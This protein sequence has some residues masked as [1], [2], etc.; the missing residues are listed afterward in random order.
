[1]LNANTYVTDNPGIGGVIRDRYE[2][3]YVE[4]IPEHLPEGEGPNIWIWIEKLGRT[5]LDVV[6][7]ISRDLHISRK[8]TGFAG[9]KDKKAITRQWICIS[10]MESDEKLQEVLDLKDNIHNT[11]FLKVVRGHKKLRMGQLK[12]NKFKINIKHI[13][14]NDNVQNLEDAAEIARDVLKQLEKTGV[15]NYFGWQRFGKPRTTTHLVGEAL[16]QNN[17]KKAVELYIGNPSDS[18]SPDSQKARQAFDD[19]D[20][21]KSL[22]LMHG[23]MRYEKMMLRQLI[24]DYNKFGELN[25][26][27]YKSALLSLPKP[28]Q[29]MFVH[30]YQSYLFNDVVSRRVAMGIDKYIE[31]DIVIDNDEAIIRD[32]TPDEYQEL[33]TNF[34]ANPTSPLYGTKVPFAGGIVGE[35]EKEVLDSYGLTKDDFECPKMPKL[36]SHGL[37]RSMRFQVW[38]TN[39]DVIEDGISVEFSINKGSYATAVLREIMKVDVV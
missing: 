31:G 20:M 4:E 36:G 26:K 2:D 37:R 30:A 18:E 6:L 23:G 9:M 24:H 33:I 12:G 14:F 10:N 5:T 11:K 34:K 21:E 25:D 28:L 17:L 22:E 13:E 15:P 32:K 8:R 39:V 38:N 3:F 1:M 16:V 27:S 35:M 7:D 29:R 19:G